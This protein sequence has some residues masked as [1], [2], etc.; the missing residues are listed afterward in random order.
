MVL[1]SVQIKMSCSAHICSH[2]WAAWR[3]EAQRPSPTPSLPLAYYYP[4]HRVNM[5]PREF[6]LTCSRA[7]FRFL[8]FVC[9]CVCARARARACAQGPWHCFLHLGIGLWDRYSVY[10]CMY[11]HL[12]FLSR[13]PI[14]TKLGMNVMLLDATPSFSFHIIGN[15]MAGVWIVRHERHGTALFAVLKW[16]TVSGSWANAWLCSGYIFL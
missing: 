9:V 14:V 7:V 8:A 1:R 6:H 16:C 10:V 5:F 2:V 13:W 11:S 4:R 15:Y 3:K 12:N